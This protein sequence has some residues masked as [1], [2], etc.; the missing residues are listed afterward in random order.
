M[1]QTRLNTGVPNDAD[2]I[3]LLG[4]LNRDAHGNTR[5][6]ATH[7]ET[8]QLVRGY[9]IPKEPTSPTKCLQLSRDL[10]K[11]MSSVDVISCPVPTV[12]HAVRFLPG[13][14]EDFRS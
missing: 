4:M 12:T 2:V 9:L 14:F 6:Q 1:I 3:I 10:H 11:M 7:Y 13:C 8:L 5:G